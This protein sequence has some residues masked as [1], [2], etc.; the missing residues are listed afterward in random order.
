VTTEDR[1]LLRSVLAIG[2]AC[3]AIGVSFGAITVAYGLPGWVAVAMSLVVFAGGA[4][5]MAVGL[6]AAGNP[7][8]AVFAGLL[9]NARHVPFGLAL[10]DTLGSRLRDKLLGSHIMTDESVAFALS[11]PAGR[12]RRR[13]YWATGATLFVLWNIGCGLGVLLGGAAGDPDR[14]GLDAAFPAGLIA[15][16]LPALRDRDTR[17]VALTGAALAVGT[18]PFLPA[19]L[20]VLLAL[21]GLLVLLIIRRRRRPTATAGRPDDGGPPPATAPPGGAAPHD[22]GAPRDGAAGPREAAPR[23]GAAGPRT[24]AASGS[25]AAV[26]RTEVTP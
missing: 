18:T 2:L 24:T 16:I 25:K 7:F 10:G 21:G 13:A 26:D 15:L 6:L 12:P 4:Q 9:L 19:G 20:P 22:G 1:S 14:L 5:F 11:R 23:A 3:A 17:W 8:A